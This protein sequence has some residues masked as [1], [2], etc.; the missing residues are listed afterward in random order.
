MMTKVARDLIEKGRIE[1]RVEEKEASLQSIV[2]MLKGLLPD[3]ESVW[4][5]VTSEENFKDV[6]LSKIKE[7][8]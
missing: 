1:G 7:L 4:R 6:P 8:Y 3:V 2:N 5:K